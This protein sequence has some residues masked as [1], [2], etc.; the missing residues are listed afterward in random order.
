MMNTDHAA[1]LRGVKNGATKKITEKA[2]NV[3]TCDIGGDILHD[4]NNATKGSFYE[5]FPDVVKF[6]DIT[7]QDFG[8][9]AKK[10]EKFLDI[11]SQQ[12]LNTNKPRKWCRSRFL[13]RYDCVKER[14][15]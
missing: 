11:C 14:R 7:R 4:I 1:T 8:K 12:G 3:A 5:N 10:T 15:K 13:S 9:S 6:L 2:P